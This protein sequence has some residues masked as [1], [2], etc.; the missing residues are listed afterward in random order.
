MNDTI[1][2]SRSK[3]YEEILEYFLKN[4]S[5]RSSEVFGLFQADKKSRSLVSIKRDLSEM[6]RLGL[7]SVQ[8]AGR[9]TSYQITILGRLVSNI[10]TEKYI[11]IEPDSRFGA[12]GYNFD[13]LKG[14]PKN[15]FTKEE[16]I[17]L[18][19]ATKIYQ[20][21]QQSTSEVIR[22]KELQRLVI[23]LAWKSS[24]IEGNTYSLLDTEKL[25][26]EAKEAPGHSK[27]EAVMILNHKSA[28][29][30]IHQN[31]E[32]YKNLT[33]SNLEDLHSILISGLNV[34]KG[35][36]NSL[37]GVTGSKYKPLDNKHQIREAIEDLSRATAKMNNPYSKALFTLLG[38]SYIQP[39][40]DGN[41][42]AGR[43]VANAILMAHNCTP[44]SYRSVDEKEY[45][46][47]VLVFYELNSIIAFKKIFIDQYLFAT[48]N[49]AL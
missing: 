45:R 24:K 9:S 13:L 31:S 10:D 16:L 46:K 38:V 33:I 29:D 6:V 43:L 47:S 49:Y 14:L 20:K 32:D 3:K 22:E 2:K 18:D 40:E 25:I 48:E 12:S 35:L 19:N 34:K 23:E 1:I 8:G 26:L 37:V 21:R 5:L 4:E 17:E 7:I 15:I 27:D 39:F 11:R 41:K 44:L 36:R 28:F 30:Y 42:R